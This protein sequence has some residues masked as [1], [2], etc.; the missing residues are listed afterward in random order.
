M[1][2]DLNDLQFFVAV[3][4]HRSISAA[5]RFLGVPKSHV[6]RR[7]SLFDEHPGVRLVE[8]SNR[9]VSNGGIYYV[10]HSIRKEP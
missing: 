2:R 4:T 6:S 10:A 1:M 9:R 8:R 3:V 7:L 5:A